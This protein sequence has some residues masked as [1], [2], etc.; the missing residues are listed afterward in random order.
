VQKPLGDAAIALHP[1]ANS[2]TL[3]AH[4]YSG[5]P[6]YIFRKPDFANQTFATQGNQE[7]RSRF[8]ARRSLH[9]GIVPNEERWKNLLRHPEFRCLPEISLPEPRI[10]E[11]AKGFEP[12]TLGLQNRCS[13]D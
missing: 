2:R 7:S 10:L 12:P 13:T 5:P 8:T 3:A 9:A 1:A 4:F 6:S 11:L